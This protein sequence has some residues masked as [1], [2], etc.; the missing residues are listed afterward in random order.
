MERID[1]YLAVRNVKMT[2]KA[3]HDGRESL[4]DLEEIDVTN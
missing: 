4:I 1:V 3:H 2:H